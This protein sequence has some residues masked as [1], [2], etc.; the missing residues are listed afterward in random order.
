[1]ERRKFIKYT[2]GAAAGILG[3]GL[4]TLS[5]GCA[6]TAQKRKKCKPCDK[7]KR[8]TDTPI[9]A[10]KVKRIA[11]VDEEVARRVQPAINY[12][13]LYYSYMKPTFTFSALN[14]RG[15][16]EI[17]VY[18]GAE[19]TRFVDRYVVQDGELSEVGRRVIDFNMWHLNQRI[20]VMIAENT[21]G[22]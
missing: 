12:I 7:V 11:T 8:A 19:S 17:S 9:P 10:S 1:M 20:A 4:G 5:A 16:L 22:V 6:V 18:G 2:A 13:T 21:T 15:I 14:G 3:A